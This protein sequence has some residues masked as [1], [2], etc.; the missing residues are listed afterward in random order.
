MDQQKRG[1]IGRMR[2]W[3]RPFRSGEDGATAVEFGL[4]AIPFFSLKL[5]IIETALMF[6]AGQLLEGGVSEAARQI[7]TGIVQ[8]RGLGPGDF[9]TMVCNEISNLF[10]CGSRLGIE[11]RTY[12][13]FDDA[14]LNRPPVDGAGNLTGPFRYDPGGPE[15]IVVV[16]AFYLWPLYVNFM[17]IDAADVA[18]HQRLLSATMAFRN[19]PFPEP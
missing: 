14:D 5:A 16:R 19:E 3:L 7:R 4:I 12:T 17:A 8:T 18:G 13:S 15:E 9:R 6:W 2:R 10:D 1:V 11:V